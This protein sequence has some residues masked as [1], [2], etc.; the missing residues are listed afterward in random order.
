MTIRRTAANTIK[1]AKVR[2]SKIWYM[3]LCSATSAKSPKWSAPDTA[4]QLHLWVYVGPPKESQLPLYASV[5]R[6]KSKYSA[7]MSGNP[8]GS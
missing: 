1:N 3:A 4:G 6:Q 8:R 2:A 7:T 5:Q